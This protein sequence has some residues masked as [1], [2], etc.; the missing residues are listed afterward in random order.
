MKTPTLRQFMNSLD[1]LNKRLLIHYIDNDYVPKVR[2]GQG[3]KNNFLYEHNSNKGI[4]IVKEI[5][6][7]KRLQLNSGYLTFV[8][9]KN[10]NFVTKKQKTRFKS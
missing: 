6:K 7:F 2:T 8:N 1:E 3:K 9:K 10:T 4:G 5:I